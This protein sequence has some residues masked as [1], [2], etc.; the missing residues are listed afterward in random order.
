MPGSTTSSIICAT[1]PAAS[2]S[3]EFDKAAILSV[4]GFGDFASTL[5]AIGDERN[6]KVLDRVLFPHS[7]G[8]LYTMIC[9]FIGYDKYGDEGK[10]MGL[11]PYGNPAYMDFFERLV[12]CKPNGR[13]ELDLDYFIHHREGVD[14]SFDADGNPTVAPLFSEAM[15]Q[16]VRPAARP[17]RRADA[18]RQGPGCVAAKVL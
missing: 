18:A 3:S 1:R 2:S 9:Q 6:I 12:Q 11:A 5:T 13:F 7:L 14:Y 4:D 10:V 17:P 16:A 15:V 8:I